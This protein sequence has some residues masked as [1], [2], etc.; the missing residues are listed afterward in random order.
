MLNAKEGRNHNNAVPLPRGKQTE[1]FRLQV[2]FWRPVLLCFFVL[3][4]FSL[5][6]NVYATR[7]KCI[8]NY[9]LV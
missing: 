6:Q 5:A 9:Y 3:T 4:L 7:E 2:D 1:L 8:L